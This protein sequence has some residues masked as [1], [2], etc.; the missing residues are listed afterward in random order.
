MFRCLSRQG[1]AKVAVSQVRH[2]VR[3]ASSCRS[4]TPSAA[5]IFICDDCIVTPAAALCHLKWGGELVK[6]GDVLVAGTSDG[7]LGFIDVQGARL[8]QARPAHPSPPCLLSLYF[9]LY[10]RFSSR[11]HHASRASL[12]QTASTWR[13]ERLV[14]CRKAAVFPLTQSSLLT[15]RAVGLGLAHS[16]TATLHCSPS[17]HRLPPSPKHQITVS[18]QV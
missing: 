18:R 17:V 16:N 11:T 1:S 12:C 5:S 10:G 14:A 6:A 15:L 3:A 4:A 9:T 7:R 13:G 2:A 8:L